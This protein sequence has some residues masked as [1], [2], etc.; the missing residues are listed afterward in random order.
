M[1]LTINQDYDSKLYEGKYGCITWYQNQVEVT[2]KIY[3]T[4]DE[5]SKG[6]DIVKLWV[7]CVEDDSR[8]YVG[9]V[10]IGQGA[11]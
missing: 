8:G 11:E 5:Y 9:E 4:E 6:L 10:F 1:K 2:H 7:S 3:S